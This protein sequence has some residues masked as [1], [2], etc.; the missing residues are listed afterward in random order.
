[1]SEL[2]GMY[3][4][5]SANMVSYHCASIETDLPLPQVLT[6]LDNEGNFADYNIDLTYLETEGSKRWRKDGNFDRN[7]MMRSD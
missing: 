1:M 2:E 3:Q 6:V 7:P 5:H 4:T